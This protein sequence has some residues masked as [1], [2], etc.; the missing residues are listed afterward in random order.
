MKKAMLL[1]L[2][3]SAFGLIARADSIRFA[4]GQYSAGPGSALGL[5]VSLAGPYMSSSSDAPSSILNATKSPSVLADFAPSADSDA[6]LVLNAI[7]S[8]NR[9]GELGNDEFLFA[10]PQRFAKLWDDSRDHNF[11]PPHS[12]NGYSDATVVSEPG[13]LML[14]TVGLAALAIYRRRTSAGNF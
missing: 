11:A 7:D 10:D 4:D 3:V 8:T 13:T 1:V 14:I 6:P 2:A 9:L 5:R 12:W